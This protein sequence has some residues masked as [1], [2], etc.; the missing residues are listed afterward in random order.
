MNNTVGGLG[1]MARVMLLAGT[2]L[3]AQQAW[4][5]GKKVKVGDHIRE[6]RN[7]PELVVLGAGT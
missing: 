3:L 2:V 5:A 4:A 1:S 6:C 7:C